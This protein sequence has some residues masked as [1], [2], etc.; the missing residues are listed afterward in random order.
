MDIQEEIDTYT[1]IEGNFYTTH[2]WIDR[3]DNKI[4]KD[5]AAL[6]DTLHHMYLIDIFR[7]FHPKAVEY[8]H[9]SS[10]RRMFS[11]IDDMLGQ[12]ISLD[13]VEIISS[14]FFDHNAMKLENTQR[15]LKN[16]QR[17]ES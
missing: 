12:K 16:T 1:V 10:A 8:T 9:F 2:Q 15:T 5:R 17:H 11:R 3:P 14:I 4:N 13:K 6:N 7:V